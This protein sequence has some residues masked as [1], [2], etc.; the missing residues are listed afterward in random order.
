MIYKSLFLLILLHIAC[1]I[2]STKPVQSF[3]EST[4]KEQ[5]IPQKK[6][7]SLEAFRLNKD[8]GKSYASIRKEI[9]EYRQS[10]AFAQ[11]QT[12]S[13]SRLFKESLLHRIIPYW[14]GTTWSFEGH[15]STPKQ[16]E[17]ACGYFVSTTL[18]AIGMPLNRY[19]LA[20]QAPLQE[21]KSLALDT[22]VITINTNT[23]GEAF[24]QLKN[25]CKEGLYFIGFADNHVGF[26]YVDQEEYYLIHS[27]YLEVTYNTKK[28]I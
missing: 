26:M 10:T 15:T 24:A 25:Q 20:Q 23:I 9:Q 1:Q 11:L 13:L 17:I 7:P 28:R 2:P 21:A 6:P 5:T 8:Q 16:G 3:P 19:H 14:E 18:K 27:N 4:E 22:P 12:D